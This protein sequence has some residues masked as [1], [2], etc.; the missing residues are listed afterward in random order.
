MNTGKTVFA[1]LQEHL[2]LH[3]FRRFVNRYKGTYKVQS[4]T[5]LD[6]Y[7]SL[8]IARLT[9]RDSLRDITACTVCKIKAP[10]YFKWVSQN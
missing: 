10:R 9:Y 7:L 2:A 6:Q 5:C 8:F 3:Q 4:F 1:Q